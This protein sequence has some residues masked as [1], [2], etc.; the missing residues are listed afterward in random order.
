MKKKT[1]IIISLVVVAITVIAVR[2]IYYLPRVVYLRELL[3]IKL[4]KKPNILGLTIVNLPIVPHKQ[5]HSLSCEIAALKIAL[6]AHSI[7]VSEAE[8]IKKLHFDP[9]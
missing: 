6:S 9:T 5:E 3:H 2:Q 1:K 7:D 8:L 4:A